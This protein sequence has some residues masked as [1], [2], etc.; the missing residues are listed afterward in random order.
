MQNYHDGA[1]KV[2]NSAF[3]SNHVT[4]CGP[5]AASFFCYKLAT[6]MLI[7]CPIN[8]KMVLSVV[9]ACLIADYLY[10]T[11]FVKT[12]RILLVSFSLIHFHKSSPTLLQCIYLLV[13]RMPNK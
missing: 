8:D 2:A 10:P 1:I 9:S 11:F 3:Y 5:I 13:F 4:I 12:V 6:N 7:Y